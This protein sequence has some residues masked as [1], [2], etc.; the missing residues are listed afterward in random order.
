MIDLPPGCELVRTTPEFDERT[1]PSGLLGAHRVATG[2]WGRLVVREGSLHFGFDDGGAEARER[3]V[4][5]GDSQVIPPGRPHHLTID[6][7][8]RFVVE[9]HRP[10]AP[11]TVT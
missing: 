1:V 11:D 10:S 9:F 8:V 4:G 7:A 3:V 5:A 6:G 2:V